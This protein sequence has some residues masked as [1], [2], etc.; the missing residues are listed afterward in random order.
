[1]P[2]HNPKSAAVLVSAARRQRTRVQRSRRS[3]T[4]TAVGLDHPAA[5]TGRPVGARLGRSTRDPENKMCRKASLSTGDLW[6]DRGWITLRLR[7]RGSRGE[8]EM[9]DQ[10]MGESSAYRLGYR[11]RAAQPRA[12]RTMVRGSD[13]E[14]LLITAAATRAGL[15]PGAWV[16]EQAV[17]A[18]MKEAAGRR[19]DW[20]DLEETTQILRGIQRVNA[21]VASNVNQVAARVHATGEVAGNAVAVMQAAQHQMRRIDEVLA[22]LWHAATGT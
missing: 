14:W 4:P 21:G 22:R 17:R 9:G 19:G 6:Q 13:D 20:A 2:T 12:N 15:K 11:P 8:I 18:A 7:G 10:V 3:A 16:A 5:G 1:M